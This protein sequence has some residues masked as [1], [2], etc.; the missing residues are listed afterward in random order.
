MHYICQM[1][2]GVGSFFAAR[3]TLER[4]GPENVT[5]LFADVKMEDEDLYRF[6]D[7]CER[8]LAHPVTRIA[9]GR[10]PWQVFADVK[11]LGNTRI[12]PCSRVLKR[13]F[14][15]SWAEEHHPDASN[16][17]IVIGIDWTEE[18]RLKQAAGRYEP[19]GVWA[20]LCEPPYI[21]KAQMLQELADIGIAEPRLYGMGFPHNNCGGFCIKAG[22]AQFKML[23]EK[24]PDRYAYH[25]QKEQ[26]MRELLGKDVAILRDRRGGDTKP[27][28]LAELR[29]RVEA[30]TDETDPHDLGG[31]GCAL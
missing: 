5:L 22:Q 9:E 13:D 21:D 4:H 12:D 16:A 10:D 11:Y 23:L 18:H 15:R 6:L 29:R 25:E 31:C 28:T 30:E 27:L 7:D 20:P 14:L 2:G 19:Y 26:E 17:T 1:S 8:W 3:R 24:M